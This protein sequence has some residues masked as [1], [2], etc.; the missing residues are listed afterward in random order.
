M[1]SP[2]KKCERVIDTCVFPCSTYLAWY[3]SDTD[4]D[5]FAGTDKNK[6]W[7]EGYGPQY[8]TELK[9]EFR[10]VV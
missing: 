8:S 6:G 9:G 2:C 4:R 7:I 5:L 3:K 1:E 10:R